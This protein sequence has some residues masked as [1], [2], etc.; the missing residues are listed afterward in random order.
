MELTDQDRDL[1]GLSRTC[2]VIQGRKGVREDEKEVQESWPSRLSKDFTASF[3]ATDLSSNT[4][5]SISS[6]LRGRCLCRALSVI[7][8]SQIP[9]NYIPQA[10]VP[11]GFWL[12]SV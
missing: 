2:L 11:T 9:A 3:L 12:I 1:P 8:F 5:T 10:T 7:R 6:M 4:N